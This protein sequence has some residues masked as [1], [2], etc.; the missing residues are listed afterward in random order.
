MKHKLI[1]GTGMDIVTLGSLIFAF[2]MLILAFVFEGGAPGALLQPTAAMIVFG[3][4]IGAVG[5]S[6][7]GSDLARFPKLIMKAFKNE[8]QKREDI[9][10]AFTTLSNL[11]RKEGLLALEQ[12]VSGSAYDDFIVTGIRLVIDGAEEEILKEVM[13]TKINN[14]EDRHERG[15]AIFEAAGGY[16]PTMGIIGTV[17]GLV[18]VLGDLSDPNALGSKIAVAFIATLYGVGFANLVWLPIASKL[19]ELNNEEIITKNM[20]MEGIILIRNGSNP[21]FVNEHL[22]GYL[23][24]AKKEETKE[25]E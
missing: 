16:S 10:E 9:I 3:G 5:V 20:M 18:H 11:S 2:V 23:N 17:M 22:K 14:M 24:N 1:G 21:N 7:K 12:E 19:K 4:T 6:F 25:G 13:E 8:K 15:I